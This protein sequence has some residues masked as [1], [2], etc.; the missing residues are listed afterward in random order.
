MNLY[1]SWRVMSNLFD[2][3][4]E[5][6]KDY[7]IACYTS[8]E[9]NGVDIVARKRLVET[10]FELRF[11]RDPDSE[12]ISLEKYS[13]ADVLNQDLITTEM[14]WLGFVYPADTYT[15]DAMTLMREKFKA[16]GH[17]L[18]IQKN[19]YRTHIELVKDESVTAVFTLYQP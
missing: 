4:D 17:D 9:V 11:Q 5:C 15:R 1:M 3:P 2:T 12:E 13:A 7:K 16:H 10:K 8:N 19:K 6:C 14:P 18:D